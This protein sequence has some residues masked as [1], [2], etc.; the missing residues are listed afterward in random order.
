M[1]DDTTVTRTIKAALKLAFPKSKFSVTRGGSQIRWTD[2]GPE[3]AAVEKA[4]VATGLV[5]DDLDWQ[6]NRRLR[7][8]HSTIWFDRYNVAER[9]TQQQDQERRRAEYAAQRQREAEAVN[10]AYAAKRATPPVEPLSPP[11]D[12]KHEQTAYD[13]F[14]KLRQ[15]AEQDVASEEERSRRPSWA[16]PLII[17]GELLEICRE[18]GYLTPDDK[19]IV[20]LWAQFADPKRVGTHLRNTISD[21]PLPGIACRGFQLHPG[22]ERQN[23]SNILFEAQRE[24]SGNWW[25]GPR[26]SGTFSY[27]SSKR[28]EWEQAIRERLRAQEEL[29]SAQLSPAD[30]RSAHANGGTVLAADRRDRH[31][32]SSRCRAPTTGSN[33][34]VA[35]RSN[36]QRRGC[37][38][39]LARRTPRCRWPVGSVGALLR[40]R[41]GL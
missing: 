16:P 39:L 9:A 41:Q 32:G 30:H 18:L 14:E 8:P 15:R 10:A 34:C 26:W 37:S 24:R 31:Q 7:L 22:G 13:V 11:P 17:D 19:P 29:D 6:D 12:P 2:D 3:L 23:T 28:Y 25:F 21:L 36:W 1:T 4:I 20:R 5:E 38:N 33:H 35:A 40:L 27:T